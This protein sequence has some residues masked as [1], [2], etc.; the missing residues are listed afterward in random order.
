MQA[1]RHYVTLAIL[2]VLALGR[3]STLYGSKPV[4]TE[5]SLSTPTSFG[6]CSGWWC[7]IRGIV[8]ANAAASGNALENARVE[9]SQFSYCSPT[10]GQHTTP[11]GPDGT[12]EFDIYVHDTDQFKVRVE[13]EGYE[14]ASQYFDGWDCLFCG[15]P[16]VEIVLQ[17]SD[18]PMALDKRATPGG[19]LHNKDF[20]TYTLTLS[21]PGLSVQLWDTLPANV[22]Y[23]SASLTSNITPPAVYSPTVRSVLW[24]GTLSTDTVALIH[25][26]VTPGLTGTGSLSLALPI[27][28][29]AWMTNLET[30]RSI[31]ATVI[32]NAVH[33]Y[34]PLMSGHN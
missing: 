13:L 34:L 22:R 20:L 16:P 29:T 30:G 27:V 4:P 23:V 6:W 3:F 26:Q 12:F 1:R 19:G 17:S 33:V 10:S 21:G 25:F 8:F 7:M 11:T 5:T 24:Q 28:N 32:A 2:A 14:S 15:C 9:L 18:A 31:S